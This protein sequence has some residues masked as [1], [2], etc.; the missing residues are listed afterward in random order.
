[1]HPAGCTQSKVPVVSARVTE[2]TCFIILYRYANGELTLY[3]G[4]RHNDAMKQVLMLIQKAL[5]NTAQ[6]STVPHSVTPTDK[7]RFSDTLMEIAGMRHISATFN[8]VST[9]ST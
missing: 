5:I 4:K 7:L 2:K 1:M 3:L 9:L 6:S 8:M